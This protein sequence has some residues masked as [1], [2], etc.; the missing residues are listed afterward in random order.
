M[1]FV[2]ADRFGVTTKNLT[3]ARLSRR[4]GLETILRAAPRGPGRRKQSSRRSLPWQ[5]ERRRL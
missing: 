5:R 4:D 1:E 3:V 2:S